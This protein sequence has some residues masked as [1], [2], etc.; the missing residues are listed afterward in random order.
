MKANNKKCKRRC[1][2]LYGYY[3]LHGNTKVNVD[4][5]ILKL[6]Y[7]LNEMSIKTPTVFFNET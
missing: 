6:I 5:N 3:V 1:R 2:W 4:A 7:E